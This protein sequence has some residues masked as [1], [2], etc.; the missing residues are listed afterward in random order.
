VLKTIVQSGFELLN[1]SLENV[2]RLND[3]IAK[4]EEEIGELELRRI[5]LT[6]DSDMMDCSMDNLPTSPPIGRAGRR[7]SRNIVVGMFD[8]TPV[9][10]PCKSVKSSDGNRRELLEKERPRA[11]SSSQEF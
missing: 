4:V 10:P 1:K 2:S 11:D 6:N 3:E 5:N 8:T 7:T 9:P